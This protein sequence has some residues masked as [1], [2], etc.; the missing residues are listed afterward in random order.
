[1]VEKRTFRGG[2]ARPARALIAALVVGLF[3]LLQLA[4]SIGA[5][6]APA[7]TA[8]TLVRD[9]KTGVDKLGSLT[10]ECRLVA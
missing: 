8:P 1:M 3:A 5:S 4:G 7:A 2:Q 6:G 9:V 10:H